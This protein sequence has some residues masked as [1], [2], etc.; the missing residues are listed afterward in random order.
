[1]KSDAFRNAVNAL[2]LAAFLA[3]LSPSVVLRTPVAAEPL[4]GKDAIGTLFAILFRTF[5]DLRFVGEFTSSDRDAEV[6]HFTWRI[7]E[8]DAE[9][10]DMLAFDA[11]GLVERYTV[12][13]RPLSA[14]VA[15][16]DAV[17][18]QLPDG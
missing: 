6:L 12:M 4:I 10:I 7:G 3:T 15:L 5:D 17:W 2:D 16:R 14:V 11:A 8:E 13:V 18:P 9:G 1:M